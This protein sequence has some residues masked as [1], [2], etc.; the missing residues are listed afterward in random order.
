MREEREEREGDT[1][2]ERGRQTDRQAEEGEIPGERLEERGERRAE[3]RLTHLV[4][5][6]RPCVAGAAC[7]YRPFRPVRLCRAADWRRRKHPSQRVFCSS[8]DRTC[9]MIMIYL[10][11]TNVCANVHALA[12]LCSS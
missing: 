12:V 2:R 3:E 8:A 10:L 6:L 11:P 7:R 5:R 4:H 9:F 1:E